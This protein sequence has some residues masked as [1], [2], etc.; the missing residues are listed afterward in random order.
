MKKEQ[1]YGKLV[2]AGGEG[3]PQRK[4]GVREVRTERKKGRAKVHRVEEKVEE[5]KGSERGN[6]TWKLTIKMQQ[7]QLVRQHSGK[8]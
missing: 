8:L 5:G 3:V 4:K 7:V 1:T 2:Q 6:T